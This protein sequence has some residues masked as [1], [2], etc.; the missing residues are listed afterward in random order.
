LTRVPLLVVGGGIGGL[1]TAIAASK[2]G[3][4][5]HL[6]EKAREFAEIGAGIQLAPNALRMLDRLGLLPEIRMHAIFPTRLV[7]MDAVSGDHI[8]SIDIGKKFVN[9]FGYPY[10]VIHRADLLEVELQACRAEK[11]ITLENDKDAVLVEDL[12]DRA[13]VTCADGSI[14]EADAVVGA[15]GLKSHTRQAVHDDG[16]PICSEAVAYRGTI[17]VQEAPPHVGLDHM[18]IWVG[19]NLHLVTY[20]I[21]HGEL[22]NLVAVFKSDRYKP[23]SDN[24]GLPD[25]LDAHFAPMCQQVR[26]G[27]AKIKR[28]RRWPM[29]DRRPISNWTRNRITLIGDAAHPMLQYAAQ[30]ACQ[31]LEDAVCLGDNL[32]EHAGAPTQA[33]LR[34]QAMRLERTARVQNIARLLNDVLHVDGIG[35]TLRNA[36]LR[37]KAADDFELVEWL[38]GYKGCP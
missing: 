37:Q 10:I 16:E 21:R 28:N 26:D 8:M 36:L 2:A 22:L 1:A 24:W 9:H 25:E 7:M 32:K 19:P 27:I 38:Y 17:P 33:F 23:E 13:R 30:G 3:Y 20:V 31:A 14:Y 6:I 35:R 29:F 5:V 12:G 11:L 4:P 34:Y 15:D 18:T